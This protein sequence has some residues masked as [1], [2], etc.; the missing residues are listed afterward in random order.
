MKYTH[1]AFD[2][3]GTLTNSEFAVLQSLQDT[4]LS[5]RG[6]TPSKEKLA[7]ITL[8]LPGEDTLKSL[9]ISNIPAV[10]KQWEQNMEQY[11]DTITVFPG[12]SELLEQLK[13]RG[14]VMG[15]VTSQTREE[16]DVNFANSPLTPYFSI[17]VCA[18][19]T[20]CGKPA[21]DPLLRFMELAGCQPSEVL[22]I[23][24]QN[25]DRLCAEAAGADFA[26]AGWGNPTGQIP[27][28]YR[29]QSPGDLLAVL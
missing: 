14:L 26:L 28:H 21:P 16:F 10:L 4:L 27:C 23:G 1:I 29:L 6:E 20:P 7:P 12:I 11:R 22:F 8:G 24:D 5:L 3:D 19:E 9:K 18:G 2:I 25:G 13:N 15:V 17:A